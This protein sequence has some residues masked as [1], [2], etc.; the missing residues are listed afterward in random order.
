MEIDYDE[1]LEYSISSSK[2]C[3]LCKDASFVEVYRYHRNILVWLRE[4]F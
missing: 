4:E 3:G 1:G 2:L